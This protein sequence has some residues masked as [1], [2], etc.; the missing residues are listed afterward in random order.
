MQIKLKQHKIVL[1]PHEL[2]FNT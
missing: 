2:I 1:I